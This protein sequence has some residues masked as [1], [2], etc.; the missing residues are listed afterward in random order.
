MATNIPPHRLAEV[1]DAIVQLI[2]KPE[3]NVEDLMNT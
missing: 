3:S 1:V 2:D